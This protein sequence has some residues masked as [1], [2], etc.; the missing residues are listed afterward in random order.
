LRFPTKEGIINLNRRH[1]FS[2]GGKWY[3]PDN[4]LN[5]GSLEW[6]LDA[7]RYPLFDTDFYPTLGDKGAILAWT[8]IDGHVFWDGC[9]RT[10]MS[11]MEIFIIVNGNRLNA[12]GEEIKDIALK[13]SKR[14]EEPYSFEEFREWVKSRTI[15][16]VFLAYPPGGSR[17]D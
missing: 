14:V 7:I 13:V 6:V 8:I 10:A 4:V 3:E 9:K 5:H 2:S 12:F 15:S 1:I 11:S 16:D 17:V